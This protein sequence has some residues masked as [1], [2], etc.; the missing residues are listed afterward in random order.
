MA[1]NVMKAGFPLIAHSRSPGPV[2]ELVSAGAKP[3]D[4]PAEVAA[5][6]ELVILMV[7][8]TSDVETVMDGPRGLLAGSH[9]GLIVVD[10]GTHDPTAMPEFAT[11]CAEVGAVF[12]DAP[13]S[14]GEFGAKEG[15]LSI[16]VGGPTDTLNRA[17]VVLAAMGTHIV[18][19]GDVGAGMVAKA[20][21]QLVVG[22]NIQAVAEALALASAVGLDAAKVR[23]A[24]LGGFAWSRVL[25]VH[26]LRMLNHDFT[27]GARVAI[28]NKDARIILDTAERAGVDLPGFRPVADAFGRLISRGHANLDHSALITLLEN[29]YK[30]Q[31][32]ADDNAGR[33]HGLDP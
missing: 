9:D 24:L 25:E 26:G 4:H 11:R 10:M 23:D 16:M 1:L 28:H 14:G 7:P 31:S 2:K 6:S 17:L 3:A 29:A 5:Q 22:S 18:H 27:P 30:P 21:N 33:P 13:V 8:D 20:C 32:G 15:T 19:V 12:L